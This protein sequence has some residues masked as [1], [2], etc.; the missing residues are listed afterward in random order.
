MPIN[1]IAGTVA[2][3]RSVACLVGRKTSNRRVHRA[4]RVLPVRALFG[5]GPSGSDSS[6]I[7]AAENIVATAKRF[8]SP[9]QGANDAIAKTIASIGRSGQRSPKSPAFAGKWKVLYASGKSGLTA[10]PGQIAS[11]T[12]TRDGS[13]ENECANKTLGIFGGYAKEGGKL[14]VTG[15]DTYEL[16]Q[17]FQEFKQPGGVLLEEVEGATVRA[18]RVLYLDDSVLAVKLVSTRFNDEDT[19]RPVTVKPD[20]DYYMV[21]QKE[22]AVLAGSGSRTGARDV[23]DEED[24]QPSRKGLLASLG[25]V[26]IGVGKNKP[27]LA[28][29]A[30]RNYNSAADDDE[31]PRELR[32]RAAEDRRREAEERKRAQAEAAAARRRDADERRGQ[33][34]AGTG[35]SG[36]L[37]GKLAATG[38]GSGEESP[39]DARKRAAAEAAAERKRQAEE[40]RQAQL[41]AAEAK[42]REAEERRRAQSQQQNDKEKISAA[43]AERQ[44]E[45]RDATSTVKELAA[46]LRMAEREGRDA[47]KAGDKARAALER[48]ESTFEAREARLQ[49]ANEVFNQLAS[50]L[51][52]KQGEYAAAQKEIAE[53]EKVLF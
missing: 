29:I 31:D 5:K 33:K 37:F 13:Y 30:E 9:S 1:M 8:K 19:G 46:A 24:D 53:L 3:P 2:K 18:F 43:L 12:V 4:P 14:K 17:T 23:D 7:A 11:F 34:A 45:V 22:G 6:A 42:K 44:E 52:Q 41:E 40:R 36:G 38:S 20:D 35:R 51:K 50:Q 15:N 21:W 26:V 47:V 16:Y 49:E 39:V 32:R 25:T 48:V 10:L 27:S 28:T